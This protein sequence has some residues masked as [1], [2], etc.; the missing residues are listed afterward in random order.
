MRKKCVGEVNHTKDM[1][2][3]LGEILLRG[4]FFDGPALQES[5]VVD[6]IIDFSTEEEVS[7]DQ[8]AERKR[9]RTTALSQWM[10]TPS[11]LRATLSRPASMSSHPS[12]EAIPVSLDDGQWQ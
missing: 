11:A 1:C 10:R 5:S 8:A 6:E 7:E 12:L 9:G 2:V 3:E 4:S